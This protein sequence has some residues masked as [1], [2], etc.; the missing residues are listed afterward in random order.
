M[1]CIHQLVQ[2][3][4]PGGDIQQ[5]EAYNYQPHHRAG[6]ESH[7][8]AAIESIAGA[9]GGPAGGHCGGFHAQESA[10]AA[11][12]TAGQK[13]QRYKRVLDALVGQYAENG[14]QDRKHDRN[15]LIL[16]KQVGIGTFLNVGGDFYHF[17][18][19]GR[20]FQH[21]FVKVASKPQRDNRRNQGQ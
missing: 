19:A 5:A 21:F 7:L 11:E 16:A 18:V 20:R 13:R 2:H 12:E 17:F 1:S 15:H 14:D 8:Q 10:Q 6:A 4:V 9:L 3:Q